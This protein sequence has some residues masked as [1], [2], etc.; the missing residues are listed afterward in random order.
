[1]Y[2]FNDAE[3]RILA[4]PEVDVHS[5]LGWSY[6]HAMIK[7]FRF[8]VPAKELD[9][10][11]SLNGIFTT[12]QGGLYLLKAIILVDQKAFF[13]GKSIKVA[14]HLVD[15]HNTFIY[16]VTHVGKRIKLVPIQSVLGFKYHAWVKKNKL[17]Y[18]VKIPSTNEVE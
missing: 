1:M 12:T 16:K 8:D 4:V 5:P 6:K 11:R 15:R 18:I 7:G 17:I 9:K 14:S 13:F 3:R 2:T 10:C